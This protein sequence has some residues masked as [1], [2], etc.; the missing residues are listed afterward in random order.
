[1]A[2]VVKVV[3]N[4]CNIRH[5]QKEDTL[6]PKNKYNCTYERYLEE[7]KIPPFKLLLYSF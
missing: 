2:Y 4:K 3:Q 5:P 6:P 1:M 7:K